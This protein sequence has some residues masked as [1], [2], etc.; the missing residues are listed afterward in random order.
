MIVLMR[1]VFVV[2]ITCLMKKDLQMLKLHDN[3]E[4]AKQRSRRSEA[5]E[6]CY[7]LHDFEV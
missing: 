6:A 2:R 4:S 7:F 5:E 1:N 3:I